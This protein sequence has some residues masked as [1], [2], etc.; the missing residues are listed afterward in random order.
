MTTPAPAAPSLA[1]LQQLIGPPFPGLMGVT[2]TEAAADR[3]VATLKVR[4][5][6]RAS[7]FFA[8]GSL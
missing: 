4:P 8:P 6:L 3:V 5:D 2:L 7:E 1:Q